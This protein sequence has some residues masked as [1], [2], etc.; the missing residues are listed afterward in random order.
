MKHVKTGAKRGQFELLVETKNVQAAMMTLRPGE[1][2][3]EQPSN[4]H[5]SSEQWLFV[6]S[7]SGVATIGKKRGR[8]KRVKLEQDA[9]LVIEKGELHQI[10]NT[11]RKNLR[12]INFYA[13]PAY[14]EEGQPLVLSALI[15]A[16]KLHSLL[17]GGA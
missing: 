8:L 3:D 10:K 1:A 5:S 15:A 2:S 14:D 9:L 7:G 16:Q 6:L 17:K 13:P 12:T 4:E 11:G